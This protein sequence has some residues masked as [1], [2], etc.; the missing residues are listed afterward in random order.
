MPIIFIAK[1]YIHGEE[2]KWKYGRT[3]PV[4]VV[5]VVVVQVAIRIDVE[6]VSVVVV[7][8]VRGQQ[9]PQEGQ[10]PKTN[11]YGIILS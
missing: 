11:F 3:D 4:R 8:V 9:P 2:K 5:D 10:E 7:E 1:C 6:P